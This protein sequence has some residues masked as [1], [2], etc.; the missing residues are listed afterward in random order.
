MRRLLFWTVFLGLAGCASV[1]ER[2]Y[3]EDP[4]AHSNPWLLKCAGGTAPVCNAYGGRTR[5]DY[6]NCRCRSMAG[7]A[8]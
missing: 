4:R 2:A 1:G 5:R 3:R 6:A 8:T 7:G